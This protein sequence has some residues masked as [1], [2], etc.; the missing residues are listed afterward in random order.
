MPPT[1]E[2]TTAFAFHMPSATLSPK[3][4]TRLFWTITVACRWKAFTIAA[5][6]RVALAASLG[7][8]AG[9]LS[10]LGVT[11]DRPGCGSTHCGTR[12]LR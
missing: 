1:L 11:R 9:G 6:S 12:C 5:F 8:V 4:S 3:P 10:A 2:A 7:V